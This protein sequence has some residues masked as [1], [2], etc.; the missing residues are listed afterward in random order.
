MKRNLGVLVLVGTSALL[1]ANQ[2][3]LA[4]QSTAGTTPSPRQQASSRA[5][6]H[7]RHHHKHSGTSKHHPHHHKRSPK[8]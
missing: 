8:Q 6:S 3:A 5:S 2:G 7:D 4:L 1:L